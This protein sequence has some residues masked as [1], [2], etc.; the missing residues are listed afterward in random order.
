LFPDN[1]DGFSL[2]NSKIIR[3]KLSSESVFRL[4]I[5]VKYTSVIFKTSFLLNE[6][7]K[8]DKRITNGGIFIETSGT[9]EIN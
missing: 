1:E 5:V 2:P 7:D 6:P 9:P 4:N 8:I 3:W